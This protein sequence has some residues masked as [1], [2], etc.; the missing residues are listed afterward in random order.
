MKKRF[1][2]DTSVLL[3][4][5]QAIFKFGDNEVVI[6]LSV[7]QELDKFKKGLTET[8]RS[9]REVS[10]Y[11]DELRS[12]GKLTEGIPL[13]QGGS[14][15]VDLALE[16]ERGKIPPEMTVGSHTDALLLAVA[17]RYQNLKDETPIILVT[18]DTNLRVRADALGI[19]VEDFEPSEVQIDELYSGVRNVDVPGEVVDKFFA[20]R[21]LQLPQDEY[22]FFPNEFVILRAAENREQSALGRYRED[23]QMIVPLI[24]KKEGVWG[25]V[26]KNVE[27]N[28]AMD[29]L[30]DD[31]V[32][33]VSLIGKAGT[34]KTLLALAAGL[35]KTIDEG[36]YSKLLVSRPVFPMGKD[37]GYLPGDLEEK[38]NPWMQPI[39]DN[40]EFLLGGGAGKEYYKRSSTSYRDLINQGMLNI[41][42]LTYIRGRSI[43]NQYLIVDEAQNLSPHEI[44]T[45]MTRVGDN[46]KIVLTGDCYQIDNPYIDSSNNGLTYVVDRFKRECI[47]GHITLVKGERSQLSELATKLL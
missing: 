7:I 43:P 10:R 3:Y 21:K 5:P 31:S 45:I 13:Q 23:K 38:L 37:I 16:E 47:S 11:L 27:Q 1:L 42:P 26:P 25:I 30:L 41:E 28:F 32:Q 4:D 20:E 29:L 9:A 22:R 39:F 34:G 12:R 36:R 46:T 14:L 24:K 15:K 8:G 35:H 19:V 17:R 2:L 18:R 40:I 44:K 6:C 33:L